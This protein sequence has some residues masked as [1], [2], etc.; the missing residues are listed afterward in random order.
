MSCAAS[1]GARAR[2]SLGALFFSSGDVACLP[3]NDEGKFPGVQCGKCFSMQNKS[4]RCHVQLAK[5]LPWRDCESWLA[6]SFLS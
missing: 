2:G 6:E 3:R 4:T 1:D 5:W